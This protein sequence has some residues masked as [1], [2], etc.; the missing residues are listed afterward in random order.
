[1]SRESRLQCV[2][3]VRLR[4]DWVMGTKATYTTRTAKRVYGN[5]HCATASDNTKV[6]EEQCESTVKVWHR[7]D[8]RHLCGTKYEPPKSFISICRHLI[9]LRIPFSNFIE[10][11]C[12]IFICKVCTG[13]LGHYSTPKAILGAPYRSEITRIS[14]HSP[15]PAAT[16]RGIK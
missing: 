10:D 1:M 4:K 5:A 16:Y 14:P 8:L 11:D 2:H 13:R 9:N 12:L 15:A 7:A 3:V 6:Q